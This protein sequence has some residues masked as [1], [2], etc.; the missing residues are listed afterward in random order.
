MTKNKK[1]YL[2]DFTTVKEKGLTN[3]LYETNLEEIGIKGYSKRC[4]IV[5][6]YFFEKNRNE[7]GLN[8]N[9]FGYAILNSLAGFGELTK[10]IFIYSP[11]YEGYKEIFELGKY[12]IQNL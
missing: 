7:K 5:P 1:E 12:F 4:F 10:F 2:D 3:Y 9:P 11:A 8:D 6:L